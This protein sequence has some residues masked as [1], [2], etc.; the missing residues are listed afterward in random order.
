MIRPDITMAVQ[1]C[2]RFCNDPSQERKES[3]KPIYK[4]LTKTKAQGIN[5]RPDKAN[6]LE[7]FSDEDWAG[8]WQHWLLENPL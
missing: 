5:L 8:S 1:K 2:A 4:Y 6:G 3:V 7:C